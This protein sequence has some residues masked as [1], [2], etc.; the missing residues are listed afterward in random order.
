M[1]PTPRALAI[2]PT[3]TH[4]LDLKRELANTGSDF[5]P[6]RLNREF[7]IAGS[8]IG[9]LIVLS[10]LYDALRNEVPGARIRTLTLGGGEMLAAL[11]TGHVDLAFGAYPTLLSGINEQTLYEE[12][13]CCFVRPGHEFLKNQTLESFMGSNHIL[14]ST[15]GLAHAHRDVEQ[16]L[17]NRLPPERIRVVTGSFMVA[18]VAAARSDLILTAPAQV[19]GREAVQFGLVQSAPPFPIAGFKVKQYWHLRSHIDP[20]HRWLR[21][22]LRR[23]VLG[24]LEHRA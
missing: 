5:A 20:A 2:A 7:V 4:M 23:S 8:D 16:E 15:R 21:K 3:I 9:Q 10:S 12:H 17:I 11:Q 13:Y 22:A 24:E 1:E 14:V 18:L 19:I 6:A